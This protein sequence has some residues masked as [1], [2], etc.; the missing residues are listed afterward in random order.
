MLDPADE[1]TC[2]AWAARQGFQLDVLDRDFPAFADAMPMD[3]GAD[4]ARPDQRRRADRQACATAQPDCGGKPCI[5]SF[6]MTMAGSF[7]W[8]GRSSGR[9]LPSSGAVTGQTASRAPGNSGKRWLATTQWIERAR[10]PG[11]C[12]AGGDRHPVVGGRTL[13]RRAGPARGFRGE[14]GREAGFADAGGRQGAASGTVRGQAGAV[15]AADRRRHYG[16]RTAR[17]SR[18]STSPNA[19]PKTPRVHNLK[20][21]EISSRASFSF[22]LFHN[23][24]IMV[25]SAC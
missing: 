1:A 22:L 11:H 14:D 20:T 17:P 2:R 25:Q 7:R 9:R 21:L 5:R 19:V 24:T 15:Q 18:V 13:A 4:V 23:Q 10:S 16:L 6:G 3:M 12:R 8:C